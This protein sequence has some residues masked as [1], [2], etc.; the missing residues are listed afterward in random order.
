MSRCARLQWVKLSKPLW[1]RSILVGSAI[2]L[3]VAVA[4]LVDP[5]G[6]FASVALRALDLHFAARG[7][8]TPT[9]PIV[10][11]AIDEDSFDELNLT[12]PWPR[13]LHARLVDAISAARPAAI[14][15]DIVFAEPSL[16]GEVDDEVLARA[17]ARA[18][19]VVLGAAFTD[20]RGAGFVKQDLN[21]PIRPVR[22]G[23]AAWGIVGFETDADALI[24][25]AT[26]EFPFQGRSLAAFNLL[27]Y[28]LAVA[29]GLRAAP[30]PGA[31]EVIINFRGGPRTFPR[32]PYYQVLSGD[33]PRDTF[34]G[35]IVLVGATSPVLHDVFPTP[36]APRGTMPGIEI[37]ANVLETLLRGIPIRSIPRGI[38]A[39]ATVL[40]GA[41]AAWLVA[42]V[43]WP[44]AT[45][46]VVIGIG[47]ALAAVAH[48]AFLAGRVWVPVTPPSWPS[49]S[50]TAPP[51]SRASSVSSGSGAGSRGTS[52]PR[53]WARSCAKT[54]SAA[55]PRAGGGSPCCSRTFAASPPC[56]RRWNR[57]RSCSSSA[58]TS[59]S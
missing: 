10:I 36:F 48:A 54:Q 56:P 18:R 55:S 8:D 44:I 40:A 13:A 3:L 26:L 27:M 57:R 5:G 34:T 29:S 9:S 52:R 42:A 51:R 49:W 46:G 16:H 39:V 14:G 12:W 22:D 1:W 7:A 17:V 23:A 31:A 58:N 32:V 2:G 30:L 47:V 11:V 37:H 15:L 4:D 28:R 38:I 21:P 33:V 24:R 53:W 35:K 19:N 41:L 45:A 25:R 43:R 50:R 59:P 20:V 6:F